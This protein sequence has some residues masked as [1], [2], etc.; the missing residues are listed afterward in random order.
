MSLARWVIDNA[1]VQLHNA[2]MKRLIFV[3][4]VC[5]CVILV[6]FPTQT[7]ASTQPRIDP[8]VLQ[9]TADG[10]TASFLVVLKSQADVRGVTS[11]AP[12][13][14]SQGRAAFSILQQTARTSQVAIQSQ[15]DSLGVS[16]R[17]YWIV[18]M[19]A[20]EGDRSVVDA[21]AMRT[22]VLS[23]E[24]NRAFQVPLEQPDFVS[25]RAPTT[26]EWNISKIS[27]PSLWALGYTG[28]GMTYAN[29]DT[30]VEWN[31]PAL[32]SHYRGWNGTT[33][34][35]NFNWWDGVRGPVVGSS[36]C[37]YSSSIPCD[38]YGHGT[39]TMGIG[40]G[41]DGA[42][43]QIGVAPGAKWI[44]CRNMDRGWGRPETYI[45][46]FQF[47]LA[48][49]DLS[50]NNANPDL[51]P[52]AVGN[53]YGCPPSELCTVNALESAVGNL[54]AAGVFMAISAGN[55][56]SNCSTVSDPPALYYSAITV[57]ATNLN[58]GIASFS[59]RGPVTVDASN[60]RKPNVVAPGVNV[61]SSIPGD[62]YGM[63][64]GTSMAA[65]HV[66]GAV[67]LLWS[68]FPS[69]VR[70]V[71][72]TQNLLQQTAVPLT[73]SQGCGG[74]GPSQVPNNVYG[75]GRLDVF[76]AYD[77]ALHPPPPNPSTFYFPWISQR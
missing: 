40:I 75:Y 22:D 6:S 50:G 46:C 64:S 63:M 3:L 12:G 49:T 41:D 77:L 8:R 51:R 52:H 32:K 5:V 25:L 16:Y 2:I 66:A 36:S 14:Q 45:S 72:E 7:I 76:A 18:N 73:T 60:R 58:D 24:P 61:I 56:G 35:H 38:D 23:I 21:M 26:V 70:N 68:A 42:G 69:L 33:A 11:R 17:P 62:S 65:P 19:I 47:F 54:R 15:L 57:G 74:D 59:S 4:L 29:A 30:G 44:A 71:D 28:Q 1:R 53:S 37:G 34:D 10:Q 67:V 13:W 43:N 48:P 39:H 9:D 20:V 55:S 31:H 27:A